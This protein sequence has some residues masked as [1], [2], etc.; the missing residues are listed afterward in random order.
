MDTL[1]RI[2]I[3][4]QNLVCDIS[5]AGIGERS[6]LLRVMKVAIRQHFE[7]PAGVGQCP[8]PNWRAIVGDYHDVIPYVGR[9]EVIGH[10]YVSVRNR[11]RII[12]RHCQ[13]RKIRRHLGVCNIRRSNEQPS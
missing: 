10:K 3:L 2:V 13:R 5:A 1:D 7:V 8:V 9:S 11:G 6:N 4:I 12:C